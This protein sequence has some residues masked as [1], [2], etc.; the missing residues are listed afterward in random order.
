MELTDKA[1]LVTGG[2]RGLGRALGQVLSARGA[3]V[4]LVARG[5]QEL[6]QSVA[7]LRAAGGE[8]HGIVADLGD[9]QAIY[10]LAGQAAAL[11]GPIDVLIHN[12]STLG[13]LPLGYLLDG[14]CEDFERVLQ[15]NLLGPYR[16]SKALVGSMLLRGSG[17]LVHVSSDAAEQA[18]PCWG[19]YGASKAALDRLAHTLAAE[20]SGT[21]VRSF[22][23][24]PGEMDTRMHSDAVPDA[25]RTLLARPEQVAAVI[26]GYLEHIEQLPDGVRLRAQAALSG[27]TEVHPW[28]VW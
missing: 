10:P 28:L 7:E 18:Y 9:K 1:V 6:S 8:V 19:F 24:D 12:A 26:T 11:V 22:S 16:L 27:R 20:L 15:V 17:A 5:E 21:G 4:V 13:P 2:S 25:D 14:E 3:R 23:V